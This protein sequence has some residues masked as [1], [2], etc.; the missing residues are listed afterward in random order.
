MRI[1]FFMGY[2]W[3]PKKTWR[4]GFQYCFLWVRPSIRPSDYSGCTLRYVYAPLLRTSSGNAPD[5]N[6][7]L[8]FF[9][10]P[11][12]TLAKASTQGA[13]KKYNSG[14]HLRQASVVNLGCFGF[15]AEL[16]SHNYVF[17]M[18][19]CFTSKR[20]ELRLGHHEVASAED[21][22]NGQALGVN[23]SV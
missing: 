16:S 10:A 17:S 4:M 18:S 5:V 14:N 3:M 13:C 21:H 7:F 2:G 15:S 9:P 8:Y 6:F 20:D 22:W 11:F 12:D 1:S 23:R 19:D